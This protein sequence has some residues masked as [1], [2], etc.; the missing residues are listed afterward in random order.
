MSTNSNRITYAHLR[1]GDA[2]G[3]ISPHGGVTMAIQADDNGN[4]NIGVA[5]CCDADRY[6]KALGREKAVGRLHS[7][8]DK[9]AKFRHTFVGIAPSALYGILGGEVI[10]PE[11]DNELDMVLKGAGAKIHR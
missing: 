7:T 5:V 8:S 10:A 9:L 11:I 4:T 6:V 3:S 2:W 1:R